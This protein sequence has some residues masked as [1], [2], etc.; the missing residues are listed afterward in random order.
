VVMEARVLGGDG[1]L[2]AHVT[3]TYARP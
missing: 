1:R 2:A 3:G